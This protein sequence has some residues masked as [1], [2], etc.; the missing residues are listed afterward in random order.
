MSALAHSQTHVA[1]VPL[2]P[3]SG[4]PRH[5]KSPRLGQRQQSRISRCPSGKR[6]HVN[7]AEPLLRFFEQLAVGFRD[8]EEKVLAQLD[9]KVLFD[10]PDF[11]GKMRWM[12]FL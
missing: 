6:S 4:R 12:V 8:T 3:L 1:R 5:W 2:R 11:D 10:L 7:F 9:L